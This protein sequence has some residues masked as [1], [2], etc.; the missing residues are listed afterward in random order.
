MRKSTIPGTYFADSNIG[1]V[2]LTNEDRV[3]VV[4][5]TQGNV[6]LL[7]CDGMGGSN[8]GEY[9][10]SL[11]IKEIAS[12]FRKKEKFF[13]YTTAYHWLYEIVKKTNKKIYNESC[14]NE[15]YNGMGTTLTAALILDDK[16]ITAQ[17]GDSRAYMHS[18]R[19]LTQITEDQSYV[20]YLVRTHQIT[21]QE[22]RTHE[23]RN[24][25]MN[26]LGIFPAANMDIKTHQFNGESLLL[27]SDGLYNNLLA[28]DINAVLNSA[29]STIQKVNTLINL[30]N[31]NG[32][33]DNI[34]V[35]LWEATHH[36]S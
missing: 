30:A 11:A 36:A 20:A 32:G 18:N 22:A 13:S 8:R 29:C 24:V 28:S 17:M 15:F 7:V 1:K 27:C 26:A 35:V 16:V 4:V 14:E 21:E 6:L 23:K 5:N 34:S 2:R 10:A 19:K 9:A 31:A 25:I 12:S 3:E 33:S